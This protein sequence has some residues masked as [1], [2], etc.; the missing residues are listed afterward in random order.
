MSQTKSNRIRA[1]RWHDGL[2]EIRTDRLLLRLPHDDEGPKIVR[3][4]VRNREYTKR[5]EPLHPDS[6]YNEADWRGVPEAQRNEA[7]KGLSYRFRACWYGEESEFIGHGVL[8][9]IVRGD[10]QV[11]QLGYTVDHQVTGRG[12]ATELAGA[13]VEFAFEVL[14]LHRIEACHMPENKA[15]RRVLEKLGFEQEGLLRQSLK[16]DGKW[17]D[18]V[19][20]SK[21]NPN[22]RGGKPVLG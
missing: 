15:S 5:W 12:I 6:F 11:C 14:D 18:H 21:L 19:L 17:A 22:W 16:V 13:A 3:F 10:S 20:M 4:L 1:I 8:R 7:R 2:P 9:D